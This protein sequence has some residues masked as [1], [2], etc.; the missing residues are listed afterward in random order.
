MLFSLG[1]P[2][3]SRINQLKK[4]KITATI[5]FS[6]SIDAIFLIPGSDLQDA[7]KDSSYE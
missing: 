2:F 5:N 7:I 4:N 1:F 6:K 3:R